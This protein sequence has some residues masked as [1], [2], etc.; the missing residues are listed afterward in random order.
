MPLVVE[1]RVDWE[2]CTSI[3]AAHGGGGLM[4]ER[5][6]TARS[7]LSLDVHLEIGSTT[8]SGSGQWIAFISPL[9]MRADKHVCRIKK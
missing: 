5:K 4:P 6:R 9:A 2:G 1:A 7:S 8:L 3:T